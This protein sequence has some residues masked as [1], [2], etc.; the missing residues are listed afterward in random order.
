MRLCKRACSPC[1]YAPIFIFFISFFLLLFYVFVLVFAFVFS[2]SSPCVKVSSG[3]ISRCKSSAQMVNQKNKIQGKNVVCVSESELHTMYCR[4]WSFCR[5]KSLMILAFLGYTFHADLCGS[6][7]LSLPSLPLSSSFPSCILVHIFPRICRWVCVQTCMAHRALT[8][9]ICSTIFIYKLREFIDEKKVK[10][11]CTY[12]DWKDE[13][14]FI[15]I[16]SPQHS[17]CSV[18]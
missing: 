11:N 14:I 10:R 12:T 4:M 3:R 16:F 8:S 13:V 6:F 18:L 2:I 15:F 9:L 5:T 7:F 17:L 1:T